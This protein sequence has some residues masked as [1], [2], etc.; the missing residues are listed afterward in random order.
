M[1]SAYT[2]PPEIEFVLACARRRLLAV[3][4][5]RAGHA[6]RL[7]ID[8]DRAITLANA[9][10][11]LPLVHSHVASGELRVPASTQARLREA[12]ATNTRRSLALTAELID[13]LRCFDDSGAPAVPLKGPVLAQLAYGSIALRQIRD[14]DLLVRESDLPLVER[15]L[16]ERGYRVAQHQPPQFDALARRTSHHVTA[17]SG[18]RGIT[19]ELHHYLLPPRGRR[20]HTLELVAPRLEVMS[21][22]GRQIRVLPHDDLVAYLCE[23]G[24]SHAWSRLE[25]IVAVTELVR[26]GCDWRAVRERAASSYGGARRIDATLHL[27]AELLGPVDGAGVIAPDRWTRE[28]NRTAVDGFRRHPDRVV[29]GNAAR[30]SYQLHTERHLRA[31]LGFVCEMLLRPTTADVLD[32]PLPR[33][34]WPLYR[35]IRPLLLLL[36][37]ARPS[38]QRS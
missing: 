4:L 12:A 17:V 25:W 1:A 5:E 28:A 35:V 38:A 14:L 18:D 2:W 21:F 13:L 34:L 30:F 32:L 8:W 36:R 22:M 31:R 27:A 29:S 26:K 16:T 19:V 33:A 15:L 37:Y 9:H 6:A 20:P 7:G 3:D 11:L 10:G 24:A 23:H